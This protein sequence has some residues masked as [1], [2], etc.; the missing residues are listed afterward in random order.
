VT[1]ESALNP[2]FRRYF[3]F[4]RVGLP[5]A[6]SFCLLVK[7]WRDGELYGKSGAIFG[8]WFVA[9]GALQAFGTSP[10]WWAIVLVLKRQ[11]NRI[12]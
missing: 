6:V 11:I 9:A 12:Y 7:R 5:T 4:A 2:E 3:R 1:R 10:G 8:L